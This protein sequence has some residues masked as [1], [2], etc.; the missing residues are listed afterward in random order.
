MELLW[1]QAT[2][3]IDDMDTAIVRFHWI[4]ESES[5][6]E[7]KKSSTNLH[8]LIIWQKQVGDWQLLALASTRI[9]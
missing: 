1:D 3:S 9:G 5:I 6:P 7:A 2:T 8:I 4:G